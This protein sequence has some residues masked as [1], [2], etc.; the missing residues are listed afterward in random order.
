MLL[1]LETFNFDAVVDGVTIAIV[2]YIIVFA[3]LIV[4]YFVYRLFP[5]LMQI[6]L[7]KKL[8]K[9]GIQTP[10]SGKD[11]TITGDVNAAISAALFLY[12]NELHD[13]ESHIMTIKK[14]SKRYSPWSSKIYAVRHMFNRP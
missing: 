10:I 9:K 6:R 2:G 3:A 4:M 13:D 12:F 7:K 5:Y 8:R 11:L 1:L 14:V